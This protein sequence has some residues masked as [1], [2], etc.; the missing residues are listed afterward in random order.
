MGASFLTQP[1]KE[2]LKLASASSPLVDMWPLF[3]SIQS[4]AR[5]TFVILNIVLEA[6]TISL[7]DYCLNCH[8]HHSHFGAPKARLEMRHPCIHSCHVGKRCSSKTDSAWPGIGRV[9]TVLLTFLSDCGY[10][11]LSVRLIRRA[12]SAFVLSLFFE[13]GSIP[14]RAIYLTTFFLN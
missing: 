5:C 12:S 10:R 14:W 3:D 13:I 1:R 4:L 8:R 7:G 2:H 9:Q 6:M 11:S